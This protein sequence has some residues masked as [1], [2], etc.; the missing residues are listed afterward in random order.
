MRRREARRYTPAL[1]ILIAI[2]QDDRV[3]G[4]LLINY[5]VSNGRMQ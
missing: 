5:T 2:V 1:E 4:S 3:P